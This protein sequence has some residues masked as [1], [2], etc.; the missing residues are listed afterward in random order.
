MNELLVPTW[1]RYLRIL[2][3][4]TV[5]A[6]TGI[7]LWNILAET[8]VPLILQGNAHELSLNLFGIHVLLMGAISLVIGGILFVN[9]TATVFGDETF[10][11]RAEFARTDSRPEARREV[12]KLNLRMLG[13][14]WQPAL[15]LL[16]MAFVLIVAGGIL[17]NI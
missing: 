17:L 10:H 6:L 8:L 9:R 14:H 2:G 16:A 12:W 11:E 3:I 4:L 15:I 13:N 7:I 1:T 5:V